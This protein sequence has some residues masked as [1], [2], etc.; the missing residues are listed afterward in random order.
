MLQKRG[1]GVWTVFS[2]L[3][4][5]TGDNVS[6]HNDVRDNLGNSGPGR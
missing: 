2:W 3:I 4:V 6:E 1:V 5:G